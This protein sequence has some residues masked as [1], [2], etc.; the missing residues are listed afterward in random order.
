MNISVVD[1]IQD[2]LNDLFPAEKKVAEY[3]LNN[4]SEIVNLNV[5]ELANKSGTSSATV[6]RTVKHLGYEGYYQMRIMISKDIGKSET[7]FDSEDTLT[8]VQKFFAIEAERLN[9]LANTID[10]PQLIEIAKVILNCSFTHIIAVGNTTPIS[11]DLGFRLERSG[12]RC[13]YSPLY[14]QFLNH[15]N[16]G[17]SEECVIAFSRSGASKQVIQAVKIAAEKGMKIIVITG[18]LKEDLISHADYIIKINEM[19]TQIAPFSKPDSHLQEIAINDAL[20]YVIKNI[21]KAK[22]SSTDMLNDK[23]NIGILLSEFKVYG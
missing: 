20:L 21:Q 14:E 10:L 16:L 18:E 6:I 11:T 15:I 4:I 12:I 1:H 19:K 3:I 5:A 2:K 9:R 7:F 23:D 17:N 13:T 8:S 22:E